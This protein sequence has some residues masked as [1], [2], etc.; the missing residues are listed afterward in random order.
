MPTPHDLVGTSDWETAHRAVA[1]AYFP[2]ELTA[3]DGR[4]Q[5]NLTMRTVELGGVT[6]GRLTWGTAV[7]IECEY[8]GAYEVNIP[9][10]GRLHSRGDGEEIVSTPGVGTIFAADRPSLITNWTADCHVLGVKFDAEHLAQE[11]DRIHL[12]PIRRRVDLPAQVD[13][14]EAAGRSWF[15]LVKALSAQLREPSDM[16]ANPLVGPQLASA[17]TTAFLLAVVPESAEADRAHRPG[18][19]KRVLDALHDDP[20]RAWT[21]ADTATLGGTS[22]RRLQEAFAEF[23]DTTP[24][25]ALADI[26]L[27]RA[28]ADLEAGGVTVADV[29]ARWGFSSSSRFAADF[30]RRYGEQPSITLRR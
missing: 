23:V 30:R 26:R 6:I 9:L 19:V 24:T 10:S 5:V 15:S 28:R 13:L 2:H 16:L 20:A 8:P 29:A 17:V 7:S 3:L 11:A 25:R 27:D 12:A 4:A 18:M 21:L 1:D 22:V 14:G